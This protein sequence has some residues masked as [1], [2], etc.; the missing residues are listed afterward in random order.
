MELQSLE[1]ELH[2][3]K[4]IEEILKTQK[5]HEFERVVAEILQVHDFE[6]KLNFR[7]KTKCRYEIDIVGIRNNLILCVDCKKWSGGRYKT[8]ALKKAAERQ[9]ERVEELKKFK[10][11]WFSERKKLIPLI[12]TLMEEELREVDGVTFVPISKLNSFLLSI[13]EYV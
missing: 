10:T 12:V 6:T 11:P 5:W 3:R 8:T 1:N 4:Q 7:F 13:D 9:K 2:K